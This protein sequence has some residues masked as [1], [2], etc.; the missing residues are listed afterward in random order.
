VETP[1]DL[2]TSAR[3]FTIAFAVVAFFGLIVSVVIPFAVP[4]P[5]WLTISLGSC[6][7]ILILVVGGKLLRRRLMRV[8]APY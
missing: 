7:F 1:P 6:C 5:K 2:M 3:R 4:G 8:R